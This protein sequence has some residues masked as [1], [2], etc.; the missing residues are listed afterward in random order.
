MNPIDSP[1]LTLSHFGFHVHDLDGMARFYRR[2][3]RFT[4]TD[5]G[6]LGAFELVFLSRDPDEHHQLALVSGRPSTLAFNPIN[7][8]SLR[9]PDL[10]ALRRVQARLT[11]AGAS[12]LEPSTHGN[13]ISLYAR[14]PEGNRLE[15]FMDLP[16]YCDQPLR[17]PV[18]LRQDDTTV[19]AQA[20]AVARRAPRFMTRATWR[21][22]MAR[23]MH[24]DQN[25]SKD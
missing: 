7:Q 6:R 14:D 19:L 2:A 18:D 9:V 11:A 12:A 3:L 16:W 17:Q 22:E 5:R 21:A 8:I 20:E 24:S 25:P 23:R 1:E 13:A 15:I 4:E 10:P